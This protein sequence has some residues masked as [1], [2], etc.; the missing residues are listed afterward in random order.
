MDQQDKRKQN[1]KGVFID[2]ETLRDART[3]ADISAGL[4][5]VVFISSIIGAIFANN[6]IIQIYFIVIVIISAFAMGAADY[7]YSTLDK[8]IPKVKKIVKEIIYYEDRQTKE[9]ECEC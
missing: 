3:S 2:Y 4:S 5:F 7:S 6:I 8:F 9:T 1:K